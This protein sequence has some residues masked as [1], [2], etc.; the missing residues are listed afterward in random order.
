MLEKLKC[1]FKGKHVYSKPRVAFGRNL[2]VVSRAVYC[3]KCGKRK[4]LSDVERFN[5]LMIASECNNLNR[6]NHIMDFKQ[7]MKTMKRLG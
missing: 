1:Y 3:K 2:P 4:E 6:R 5:Y 7:H